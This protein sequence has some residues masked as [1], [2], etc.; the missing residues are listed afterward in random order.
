MSAIASYEEFMK[1]VGEMEA[2]AHR[3]DLA[4]VERLMPKRS[5]RP[6]PYWVVVAVT[7]E[8]N[9]TG[10]MLC[11]ASKRDASVR[12]IPFF[13]NHEDAKRLAQESFLPEQHILWKPAEG[14]RWEARGASR[15]FVRALWDD[16]TFK[17]QGAV[18]ARYEAGV[19][20]LER[21]PQDGLTTRWERWKRALVL[22]G[23]IS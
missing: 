10:Q 7:P 21:V 2:Q 15:R 14:I 11:L 12:G 9:A 22:H 4:V 1:V 5:D 8:G 17:D 19:I 20:A 6:R 18:L 23:G 13:A 3:Q 16:G